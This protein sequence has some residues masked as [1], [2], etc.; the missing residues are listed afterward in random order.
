MYN[1]AGILAAMS[2]IHGGASFSLFSPTVFNFLCG[3]DP[4]KLQ[5]KIEEVADAA[6]KDFL[7]KV[8]MYMYMCVVCVGLCA[9]S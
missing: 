2:I 8:S 6:T 9:Y 5:P 3:Q 7:C 4:A 1:R